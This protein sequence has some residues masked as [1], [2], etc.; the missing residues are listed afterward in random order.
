MRVGPRR[1]KD[2]EFCVQC[3]FIAKLTNMEEGEVSVRLQ[4]T[5]KDEAS[6]GFNTHLVLGKPANIKLAHQETANLYFKL[7]T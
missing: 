2:F 5:Q 6:N 7:S 1:T 3:R 4:V